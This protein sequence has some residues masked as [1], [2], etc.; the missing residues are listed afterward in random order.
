MAFISRVA[1]QGVFASS[2]APVELRVSGGASEFS[3]IPYGATDI[4]TT[5][6]ETPFL[7]HL[8]IKMNILRRQARDKHRENSKKRGIYTHHRAAVHGVTW[9]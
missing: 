7:R 4:R 9:R 5:G 6:K 3:M 1:G 8:Y 2:L